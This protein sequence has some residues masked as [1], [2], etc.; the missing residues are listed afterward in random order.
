[1]SSTAEAICNRLPVWRA[2]LPRIFAGAPLRHFAKLG[3]EGVGAL[4]GAPRA[5]HA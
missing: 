3:Y 4:F 2:Q 1:M 5:F